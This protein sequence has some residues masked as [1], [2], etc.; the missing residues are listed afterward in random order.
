MKKPTLLIVDDEKNILTSLSRSLS[1]NYHVKTAL[2]GEESLTILKENEID[3]V[4]LDVKLPG[5]DGLEVLQKAMEMD[6]DLV[7]IVMSAHATTIDDAVKAIKL[8]AIDY[9]EKPFYIKYP[10]WAM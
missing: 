9:L 10:V 6:R 1:G 7:V 2:T 4:L 5:M 3:L 8:G